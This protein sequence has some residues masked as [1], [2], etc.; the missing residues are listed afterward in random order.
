MSTNPVWPPTLPDHSFYRA[1]SVSMTSV[2]VCR[3]TAERKKCCGEEFCRSTIS[4]RGLFG[5]GS[6]TRWPLSFLEHI[7]LNFVWKSWGAI[8]TQTASA[9]SCVVTPE[10]SGWC[11][12][13]YPFLGVGEGW[14]LI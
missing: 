11:S 14:H 6:P 3:C 4:T 13:L 1:G 7:E 12:V 9:L 8:K 2:P 5:L 10:V